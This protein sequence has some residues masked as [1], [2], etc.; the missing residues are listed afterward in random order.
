M[1]L[2]V[3]SNDDDSSESSDSGVDTL[4]TSTRSSFPSE[5]MD[6]DEFLS[7]QTQ[8][9]QVN[10]PITCDNAQ[11]PETRPSV[12]DAKTVATPTPARVEP[13]TITDFS[14][15]RVELPTITD[16]SPAR[17]ELPTITDF[18][19]GRVELPAITDFSKAAAD[20]N[21]VL[22]SM[23][24]SKMS[25]LPLK[26]DPAIFKSLQVNTCQPAGTSSIIQWCKTVGV[27]RQEHQEAMGPEPGKTP[28][29]RR[30]NCRYVYN[31]LPITKKADRKFYNQSEKDEK[32][33]ERR[34]KNNVAAKRSRDS[35]RQKE[36]EVTEKFKTLEK[37]NSLLKEEVRRLRMKAGELE[38]KLSHFQG[39]DTM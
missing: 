29:R 7:V 11:N 17:V 1:P 26:V 32:Y 3:L 25:T 4:S 22:T 10:T 14:P 28:V 8:N 36:I 27:T 20:V 35:R 30:R 19:P 15:A 38:N 24:L 13:P 21:S 39:P 6:L 2:S 16:F 23:M 9:C 18:S 34:I 37:E 5:Y 31:P 12:S 33:W